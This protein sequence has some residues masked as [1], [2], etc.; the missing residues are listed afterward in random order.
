MPGK[1]AGCRHRRKSYKLFAV[2]WLAKQLQASKKK[3][4]KK[5]NGNNNKPTDAEHIAAAT[6]IEATTTS[7]SQ[8]GQWKALPGHGN[9]AQTLECKDREKWR[10]KW[11]GNGTKRNPAITHAHAHTH[12]PYI[13]DAQ[14]V[15]EWE[16]GGWTERGVWQPLTGLN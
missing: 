16:E 15:A 5:N 4:E 1:L 13:V 14:T 10:M 12:T 2:D 8:S 9:K 11:S 3:M 6:A 7:N